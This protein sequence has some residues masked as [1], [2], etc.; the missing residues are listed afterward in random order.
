MRKFM[1]RTFVTFV[2][3]SLA[4]IGHLPARRLLVEGRD[5]RR[6]PPAR[7]RGRLPARCSSW[8]SSAAV[9]TAAYMTRC[10]YLTFFGEPRGHAADPHHPPHES[11]PAHPR[12]ALH[13]V[14]H[15]HRRRLR[16]PARRSS[17]LPDSLHCGSS[18]T[19]SRSR[20][21]FPDESPTPSSAGGSRV[22]SG[23]LG[24]HRH[25]P[26]LRL[27]L[28]GPVPRRSP[29]A[30]SVRPAPATRV[31]VN[32]YYFDRLYTDVIAGGV[33]GP[34]AAGGLLVQPERARRHRQRRR[35][36]RHRG[37]RGGPTS[38]STRVSSTAPSTDRVQRPRASA[39]RF[40]SCRP[41]R[42]SSTAPCSSAAPS[43]SPASSCSPSRRRTAT[44]G[45][46]PRRLGPDPGG[47]PAAGRCRSS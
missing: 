38:T 2:I 47:V 43:S 23:R 45:S 34:I 10:I 42:S 25:R 5:P 12:A 44:D 6:R 17:C 4:L 18:T 35:R 19:S 37:R 7:R 32:K 30:T 1:P 24:L 33:K 22:L 3:C 8:A 39:R 16:Q 9:C 31:L 14:V 13:P 11:G 26:R 21:Y 36:R 40:A 41:A 15:G 27:L 29:S 20:P 28:A 46:V